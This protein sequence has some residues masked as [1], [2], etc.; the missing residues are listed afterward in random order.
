MGSAVSVPTAIALSLIT[1]AIVYGFV[2]SHPDPPQPAYTTATEE[3]A[4]GKKGKKKKAAQAEQAASTSSAE[5]PTPV[6][7]F[8]AVIPGALEDEPTAAAPAPPKPKSKKKKAKKAANASAAGVARADDA[9]SESSATAPESSTPVPRTK[10]KTPPVLDA[11]GPWTRVESRK[12]PPRQAQESA[13]GATPAEPVVSDPGITT[14]V[15]GSVTGTTEDEREQEQEQEQEMQ[16]PVREPENRRTLAEKLLPK[17]RKT[18]VEDLLEIPDVPTVARVM[19]IKPGPDDHPAQGFSW[20]DYE[21][22]D[23]RGTADDADGED[24]GGWIVK[25]SRRPKPKSPAAQAPQTASESMTKKQRQ[26][27]AKNEAAKAAKE[28]AEEQRLQLLEAHNRELRQARIA[29]QY[30]SGKKVSGG[31]KASVSGGHMVFE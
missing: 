22:V 30:A 24:E 9:Q 25:N 19:R 31:M 26:N 8:P 20:G 10:R 1:G 14:S 3:K 27:K 23:E 16:Q 12:R 15:T 6:V 29:D 18:G 5:K 28:E 4:G 17:P 2:Q 7:P 11:D 13:A 21:D